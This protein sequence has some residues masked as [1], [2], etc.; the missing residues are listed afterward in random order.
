MWKPATLF[1][2]L[3]ASILPLA[4]AWAGDEP[5]VQGE[6]DALPYLR[7]AHAKVHSLWAGNF[8]LLAA[9]QLPKDHPVN[10]TS[11]K[12]ELEMVLS[13]KGVLTDVRVAKTSGSP[14]FDT[15]ATDVVRAAGTFAPAPEAVLSDDGKV[16]LLWAFAR[17]D[18]GCS[19]LA[20]ME[21][22]LPLA[23]AVRAMVAQDRDGAA[24]A[25]LQ[26][27][28]DTERAAAMDVFARAWL[29]R[30]ENDKDLALRVAVANALSGDARGAEILR[31][32][33]DLSDTG[34]KDG[35]AA[36][37]L[38]A[39]KIPVCPLIRESLARLPKTDKG[40]IPTP[41]P[42][43]GDAEFLKRMG[44]KQVRPRVLNLVIEGTSEQCLAF[45]IALAKNRAA[46][47]MDR[48]FAIMSLE[49]SES[50]EAKAAL[51][52]LTKDPDP[53]I[54]SQAIRAEARPGAGRGAVFRIIPLLRDK[55][56]FV[57]AAAA[58]ALVRV[59]GEEVLPQLFLVFKE[60]APDVYLALAPEL[61]NM[62]G[63]PSANMLARFLRKDEPTI[64]EAAALALAARHDEHAEKIQ[65][66]LAGSDSFKLQL[67]AGPALAK[68]KRA[69]AVKTPIGD[70]VTWHAL[71]RGSGRTLA[72]EWL[73]AQFSELA[74][75]ARV[76]LLGDWLGSRP[77]TQ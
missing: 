7:A 60:K 32:A 25:R 14:E 9:S 3:L 18:R 10:A 52:A 21:R 70:K 65:T 68:E 27:A 37:G 77:K 11:R 74:P 59:G 53:R 12:V 19:G 13:A 30:V 39:L 76:E 69:A 6:E 54:Q 72:G 44:S 42:D 58:A 4:T 64:R 35:D 49:H 46:P 55:S 22:K 67:L 29:D 43:M 50:P 33:V 34:T 26:A 75:V 1:L 71:V 15:S 2:V 8:L 63:A 47:G 57:R 16:H 45:V 41:I 40:P 17:D 62:S 51:R 28:D 61:A 38:A 5:A 31:K 73:L 66:S 23:E 20:V 56:V 48:T 36:D 24:V